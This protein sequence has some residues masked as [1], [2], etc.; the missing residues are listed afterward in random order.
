MAER[1]RTSALQQDGRAGRAGRA[2]R[3]GRR[4]GR[5][6]RGRARRGLLERLGRELLCAARARSHRRPQSRAAC[7]QSRPAAEPGMH[8][9]ARARG[10]RTEQFVGDLQQQRRQRALDLGADE[11]G[12]GA[13]VRV[14]RAAAAGRAAAAAGRAPA[15]RPPAQ[16]RGR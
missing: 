15:L 16:R 7:A 2:R 12:A 9:A 10:R 5:A 13:R 14:V 1:G 11:R 6:L 3:L 4:G 8:R